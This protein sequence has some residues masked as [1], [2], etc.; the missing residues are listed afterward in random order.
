MPS[1]TTEVPH[2]LGQADAK[3]KLSSFLDRIT[4]KY[5]DQVSDL[6]GEWTENVLTYRFSTFGIRISG[7]VTVLDDKVIVHG[8]IP[9]SAM[10]FKGKI[11]S[12]IQDAIEKTLA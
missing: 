10:M 3:E 12:G 5:K 9:F 11:S 1:F 4:E 6:D 7:E 8:E 2:S